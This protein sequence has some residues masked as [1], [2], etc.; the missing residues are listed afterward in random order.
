MLDF[1][2]AKQAFPTE[3]NVFPRT[4]KPLDESRF[5][6]NRVSWSIWTI[7][8]P[9]DGLDGVGRDLLLCNIQVLVDDL[10]ALAATDIGLILVVGINQPW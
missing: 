7:L 8:I 1:L 2:F 3:F 5:G 9:R 6:V 4:T 10:V